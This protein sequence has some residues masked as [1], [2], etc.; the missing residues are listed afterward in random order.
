V[1]GIQ[2]HGVVEGQ[3]PHSSI[4][5]MA[6]VYLQEMRKVQPS[7]P[8]YLGGESFGGLVAYEMAC[9]LVQGGERVAFLFIGDAW[10]KTVRPW[11]YFAS[12]LTYPFTLTRADWVDLIKR[13]V[14]RK[15]PSV[16][17]PAIKR[18][19]Y[20]DSLHRA[21]SL[22]HRQASRDFVPR[23]YP[24]TV[25]L[26]RAR[27]QD[28]HTRRIQHYFGGPD[29]SWKRTATAVDVHWLPDFHREMMHG[30]NAAGFAQTLQACM[31]QARVA[32]KHNIAPIMEHSRG[33]TDL[34]LTPALD[35]VAR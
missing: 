15:R 13:R 29:M 22:A 8:Y 25:T 28:Q 12:C 19:V 20:A 6:L 24:G 17:T 30:V 23:R 4:Y 2:A 11:R 18:Y 14:L 31:E 10:P 26:F 9:Q 35:T 34:G 7:G 1:Y 16:S 33:A 3:T 32:E 27:E 21:N 5:Q